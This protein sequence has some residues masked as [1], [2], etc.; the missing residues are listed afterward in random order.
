MMK[1]LAI[2]L[3]FIG[4]R[5]LL[6][7]VAAAQSTDELQRELAEKRAAVATV[8]APYSHAAATEARP[9]L[10]RIAA[11]QQQ[12]S[13][14]THPDYIETL[15][16]IGDLYFA[17]ADYPKALKYYQQAFE[18][19]K[20]NPAASGSAD[21]AA[22]LT[23]IGNV[24]LRRG[25]HAEALTYYRQALDIRKMD[26]GERHPDYAASLRD[27]AAAYCDAGNTVRALDYAMRALELSKQVQGE[28]HPDYAAALYG[29]GLVHF[30]TGRHAEALQ[31]HTRALE[32]RRK[33]LGERHPDYAASLNGVGLAHYR[34]GN[35]TEA[36][37]ALQQAL[38]VQQDFQGELHPDYALT[39]HHAGLVCH[40]A[41]N[42]A[43]ALNYHKQALGILKRSTGELH[44]DYADA[45][46]SLG[47]LCDETGDYAK[48]LEYRLKALDIRKQILKKNH[49]DYILSL[50]HVGQAYHKAG[51][52]AEALKYY[53]QAL[54]IQN[55]SSG[56]D[57]AYAALLYNM[58]AVYSDMGN[59]MQ[60]LDCHMQALGIRRQA[61]GEK[62]PDY[63]A[64]LG[65]VGT[66]YH[67]M[68]N[69]ANALKYHKQAL[70][71]QQRIL[72]EQHPSCAITLNNLIRSSLSA[73]D[74]NGA[75]AYATQ[76]F[77]IVRNLIATNFTFMIERE[78]EQFLNK[79]RSLLETLITAASLHTG[80]GDL[81]YNAS[82]TNKGL[83]L[84]TSL[85]IER[86]IRESKRDDLIETSDKLRFTRKQI[87]ELPFEEKAGLPR[88]RRSADSLERI[89]LNGIPALGRRLE[90]LQMN[91]QDVKKT[92]KPTDVAIEFIQ[93]EN[94]RTTIYAA[95][96][97]RAGYAAPL[98]FVVMTA[99][100]QTFAADRY[101]SRETGL[102]IW[103]KILPH[104]QAGD[105][106][107]FAPAG[108]LYQMGI[109]YLPI[110]ESV[111]MCDRYN[112]HRVSSTRQLTLA[113]DGTRSETAVLYGGLNYNS[114]T[115]EMQYYAAAATERG[116]GSDVQGVIWR[117]L[118]GTQEEIG[119]IGPMLAAQHYTIRSY[120]GGE[121]I[122]ESFKA[123]SGRRTEIIHI[124]T[125]G[126]Y[127]PEERTDR[128]M[129]H[130]GGGMRE[131]Q[132]L[133]RSGLV[134][135]GANNK[136]G[137]PDN[138]DDGILTAREISLLDL[139]GADLVV[140]SACQT[141]LGDVTGE[142]I[143]GLPRG[144]KKAGAQT[145]LMSLWSVND[146]ATRVMMTA[147]YKGLTSG[148]S[149][150]EAFLQ[151]QNEVK[152]QR[153]TES[154]GSIHAGSEPHYWASFVM[155]D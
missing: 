1:K 132:S 33:T 111:R 150:R 108:A 23:R 36:L 86:I 134:F 131:D 16:R 105:N 98:S 45:L 146:E 117:Y 29:L 119:Q 21:Y 20:G 54:D 99:D 8:K 42:Y 66:A 153:F 152:R 43:D 133:Q 145:L 2:G 137:L 127:L 81:L 28:A 104:L 115:E 64:S 69:Y 139:R 49:P 46:S 90:N 147:F 59:P 148:R 9:K 27:I 39:L 35:Y 71:I 76:L 135:A 109:E 60:A 78:R 25:N 89:L 17:T 56:R 55:L 142:G 149:K 22:A 84:D 154:D 140:L 4:C 12:L 141:G 67:G 110:E 91:W 121:G 130:I 24:H 61:L 118:N 106:V 116:R 75:Y 100:K 15:G 62:H 92:L 3:L 48:S 87:E 124:A 57:Q 70:E 26:V 114:D 73:S 10:L 30:E 6:P 88:L 112:M 51:R 126:F 63:A 32:I 34:T 80:G 13:G 113:P 74:T 82:L 38:A 95:T 44:P 58:G 107:Y 19:L 143:F 125:H 53:R 7:T 52:H 144:F 72:G 122:E 101:D 120:T 93:F 47:A 128:S 155:M 138:L 102:R 18:L 5:L 85:E 37:A 151:A 97:L 14:D 65:G 50:N 94:N 129:M 136:I 40:R 31:A 68:G 96:L 11:L 77:P 83:L 41:G 79:Y 103:G 123:L